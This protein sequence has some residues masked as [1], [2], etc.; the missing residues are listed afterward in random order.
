M[1]KSYL[2]HPAHTPNAIFTA[3]M[4]FDMKK[5]FV[6]LMCL[7]ALSTVQQVAAQ[8]KRVVADKII[9]K[10]EDRIILQSDLNNALTNILCRAGE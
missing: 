9:G 2:K 6:F 4:N 1:L 3:I 8:T 7:L 5:G 10:V